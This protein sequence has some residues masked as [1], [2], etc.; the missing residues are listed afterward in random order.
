LVSVRNTSRRVLREI[1]KLSASAAS[2]SRCPGE[3]SP[4]TIFWR[5]SSATR[6]LSVCAPA[7]AGGADGVVEAG[8]VMPKGEGS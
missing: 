3:N 1:S 8:G 2:D 5:I 4:F 6:S 7:A